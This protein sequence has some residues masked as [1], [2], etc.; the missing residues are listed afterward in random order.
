MVVD[1]AVALEHLAQLLPPGPSIPTCAISAIC[2]FFLGGGIIGME[3]AR[4]VVV[5][6]VTSASLPI[7]SAYTV[8]PRLKRF[9]RLIE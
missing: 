5:L 4:C 9:N 6:R 8:Y 2:V 1:P 7:L 3:V